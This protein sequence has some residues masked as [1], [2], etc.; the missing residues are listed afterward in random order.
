MGIVEWRPSSTTANFQL[1]NVRYYYRADGVAVPLG[2]DF[3]SAFQL[4]GA[5]G[6]GQ[7]LSVPLDTENSSAVLE[8]ANTLNEEVK[9]EV[10][11][12]GASGGESLHQQTY[13]LKPHA[14]YHLIADSMLNGG[15]GMATIKGNKLSSL[16][17]TAMHYRRTETL[18]IENIYGV[19]A[20]EALGRAMRGSYNTYLKQGCRL[21][22]VNPTSAQAITT[23]SMKRYDGTNVELGR[24]L[25]IPAHG[26]TDYN[27]CAE[28]QENVYG[29][30]TVQPDTPNSIFATV[31]RIG[32]NEEYRFPTPVR[33]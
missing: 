2:E 19:Q 4:E 12:Y 7:L 26:L 10:S 23:I 21:F 32:E 11:I 13:K 14:T 3:E 16:I 6:N 30:V 18:G 31:L 20:S 25:A 22:L 5:V 33:E 8:I 24:K 1:R 29:V 15:K 17:A 27:L 9:A 28:E